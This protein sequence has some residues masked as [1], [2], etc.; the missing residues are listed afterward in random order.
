MAGLVYNQKMNTPSGHPVILN[1]CTICGKEFVADFK[2]EGQGTSVP[3]SRN[4]PL[5][6]RHHE[7]GNHV[8]VLGTLIAFYEVVEGKLVEAKPVVSDVLEE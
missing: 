7:G 3:L 8:D 5:R 1:T 6:V 4:L 2:M